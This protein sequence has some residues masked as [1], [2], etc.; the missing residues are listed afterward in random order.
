MSDQ[1]SGYNK[2][3]KPSRNEAEG[4]R[5]FELRWSGSQTWIWG[6]VLLVVGTLMLFQNF[7]NFRFIHLNNWWAVF[8]LVPGISN[9]TQA[10]GIYRQKAQLTPGARSRA[11][12]GLVLIAVACTFLFNLSWGLMLPILLLAGGIFLLFTARSSGS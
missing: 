4:E 10:W 12:W 5:G 6:L 9:L 8:I 7:T 1:D 11:F 2:E 3:E